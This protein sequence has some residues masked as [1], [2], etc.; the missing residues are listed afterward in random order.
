VIVIRRVALVG[1]LLRQVYVAASRY[2]VEITPV[3]DFVHVLEYPFG[4]PPMRCTPSGARVGFWAGRGSCSKAGPRGRGRPR[5]GRHPQTTEAIATEMVSSLF[6]TGLECATMRVQ[7]VIE[8]KGEETEMKIPTIGLG[9]AKTVFHVVGLDERGK[10]VM[11][12]RLRRNQV[13]EYFA[14][15]PP[16]RMDRYGGL[17]RRA[18][19]GTQA[20]GDGAPG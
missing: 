1:S 16:Y 7:T 13:A 8:P 11:R 15:L 18:S 4:P 19:L 10:E 5:R 20:A 3:Q 17:W 12:R 9:L 14:K 6:L 2:K